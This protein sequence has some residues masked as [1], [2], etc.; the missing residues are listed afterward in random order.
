[1]REGERELGSEIEEKT[2]AF[3]KQRA[4]RGEGGLQREA[5]GGRELGIELADKTWHGKREGL[6]RP[7]GLQGEGA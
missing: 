7:G 5:G 2:G 6:E 1:M 4:H 3:E